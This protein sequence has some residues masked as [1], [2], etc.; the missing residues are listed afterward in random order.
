LAAKQA[1]TG[2]GP[3][4]EEGPDQ[5]LVARI[6]ACG[7]RPV[8]RKPSDVAGEASKLS[9]GRVRSLARVL[10]L[11]PSDEVRSNA[12]P[13]AALGAECVQKL[14]QELHRVGL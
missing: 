13:G 6:F 5:P 7:E 8:P 1:A 10:A 3:R 11:E 12:S 2:Y 9:R 14:S 4:H